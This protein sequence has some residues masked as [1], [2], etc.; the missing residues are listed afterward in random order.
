MTTPATARKQLR[1]HALKH[2]E[3]WEDEP[4]PGDHVAKVGKKIFVF[5]GGAGADVSVGVKLPRSLL[6]ARAQPFVTK[7]GYGMDKSGWVVARFGKGEEIPLALL[8]SWID[9]SYE[10]VAATALPKRQR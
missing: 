8:C 9:E 2:R 10:T 7:M 5:L 4:W 1:A 3:A 6:F